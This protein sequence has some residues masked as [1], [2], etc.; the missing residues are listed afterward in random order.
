MDHRGILNSS[1]NADIPVEEWRSSLLEKKIDLYNFESVAAE[2]CPYILSSPRSLRACARMKIQPIELLSKP[3]SDFEEELLAAGHQPGETS[4]KLYDA[5]ERQRLR[6]LYMCRRAREEII[7]EDGGDEKIEVI[8]P[9]KLLFQGWNKPPERNS[10]R[11]VKGID[12]SKVIIPK[13][14]QANSNRRPGASPRPSPQS[15]AGRVSTPSKTSTTSSSSR[16]STTRTTSSS[17]S[18]NL[19]GLPPRLVKRSASMP[20]TSRVRPQSASASGNSSFRSSCRTPLS[21]RGSERPSRSSSRPRPYSAS[22]LPE[23]DQKIL[24]CMMFKR[25]QEKEDLKTQQMARRIWDEERQNEERVKLENE[26]QRRKRVVERDRERERKRE[27]MQKQREKEELEK[28]KEVELAIKHKDKKHQLLSSQMDLLKI[29]QIEARQQVEKT[30]KAKQEI[31]FKEKQNKDEEYRRTVEKHITLS[32]DLAESKREKKQHEEVKEL[33]KRNKELMK[34]HE[35][36]KKVID[37]KTEEENEYL[38]SCLDVK[39]SKHKDLISKQHLQRQTELRNSKRKLEKQQKKTHKV[40]E[41]IDTNIEKWKED[42]VKQRSV[43]QDQAVIKAEKAVQ[44][45]AQKAQEQRVIKEKSHKERI[46]R[47]IEDAEQL[48]RYTEQKIKHKDQKIQEVVAKKQ[49]EID[50]SRAVAQNSAKLRE[51][52]RNQYSRTFDRMAQKA[53]LESKIGTGP[54]LATKNYSHTIIS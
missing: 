34:Q 2:D 49:Q 8:D 12:A 4:R 3:E 25:E 29:Q 41:E 18:R 6:K 7:Q 19:N 28:L 20:P 42:I 11:N 5:H 54:S 13:S 9:T 46:A 22:T 45:K 47:V 26:L 24:D 40:K 52:L 36:R 10:G 16:T 17:G 39:D 50:R 31:L 15:S 53:E 33:Q 43:V 23:R 14:G 21:Q 37:K 44:E 51:Q 27:Q 48:A 38:R 1:S 30:K 35:A 32:L